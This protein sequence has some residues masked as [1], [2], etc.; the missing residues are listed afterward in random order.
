MHTKFYAF[1]STGTADDVVMVSSANLNKGGGTRG[2]NDIYTMVDRPRSFE[3][4]TRIHREM[5]EDIRAGSG[6][7]EVVDGPFTSRF[8]PMRKATRRNDPGLDDLNKIGCRSA[9]GRT[10]VHVNMFGFKGD[11]GKYM[12][13]KLFAL[14][15]QGCRVNIIFGAPSKVMSAYLKQK[16]RQHGIPLYNSR[17]DFDGDGLKEVRAHSKYVIV[18]GRYG[19]DASSFQVLTGSANW[20]DGG[21]DRGDES[22]L[23]IASRAAYSQYLDNWHV[24]R[25]HSV[26]S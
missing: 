3:V 14:K 10:Q 26:R 2:W 22:T 7:V 20:G 5:T 15:R 12:S 19:S 21:L 13:D 6:K 17:R 24:V 18:K 8:F 9:F 1:S 11:R 4:Y 23:N 25:R 16:S